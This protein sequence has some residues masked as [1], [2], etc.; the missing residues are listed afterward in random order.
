MNLLIDSFL[1]YM[2]LELNRASLTVDA[3]RRD[4]LQLLAFLRREAGSDDVDAS[5]V[6]AADLRAWLIE[7][8]DSGDSA[9]TLRRK[10]QAARAFFRRLQ[11]QGLVNDNPA[12]AVELAKLPRRLPTFVRPATMDRLLDDD[13]ADLATDVIAARDRLIVMMLY[14]TGMRRAELITLRDAAVDTGHGTLRVRGKRDKDRIIPFGSELADA[15]DHYRTLRGK[16]GVDD[17]FFTRPD[18]Q[19][20]YPTLVYRIVTSQLQQGGVTGKRSPHVL[21]HSFATAMLDNGAAINS[22][23]DLLGHASLAA[24][25]VYTH[26][27]FSELKHNYQLAHP[28][29]LK[30]GD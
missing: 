30:Q 19:P 26:V 8:S 5:L 2:R 4:L 25:Q 20:L 16:P 10:V 22:V 28:R 24:T 11:Q 27:T 15:I 13:N 9:A 12:K 7:R 18:G 23:K 6:T 17:A 1:Q 21:R 14:E 29:A 3:Y